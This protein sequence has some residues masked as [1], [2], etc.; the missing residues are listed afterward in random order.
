MKTKGVRRNTSLPST[1]RRD[2]EERKAPQRRQ[3]GPRERQP[4]AA[5]EALL[6]AFAIANDVRVEA[7]AR[8]V[9]EDPAVD[10]ADVD[11]RRVPF[12]QERHRVVEL[13]RNAEVLGEVVE[14]AERKDAEDDAAVDQRRRDGADRAVAAAGDDQPR[15]PRDGGVDRGGD[16][17]AAF[18]ELDLG[19]QAGGLE[20]AREPVDERPVVAVPGAGVDDDDHV[21][22]HGRPRTIMRARRLAPPFRP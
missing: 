5:A 1:T 9:D 7:Q 14:R 21:A 13:E 12:G 20:Q 16:G 11:P 19:L 17:V 8:V 15:L 22:V 2:A 4:L 18:G 10:L 6:L 3:R